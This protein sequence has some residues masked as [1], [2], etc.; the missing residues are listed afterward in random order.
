MRMR[1]HIADGQSCNIHGDNGCEIQGVAGTINRQQ[2][3][4]QARQGIEEDL[5]RIPDA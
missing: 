5:R 4:A 1:G 2:E 3:K